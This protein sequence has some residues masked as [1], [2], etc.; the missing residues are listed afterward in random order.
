MSQLPVSPTRRA[1]FLDRDGTLN[2]EHD[3][4]RTPDDLVLLPGVAGALRSL[5]DAGFALVVVTNQSARARGLLHEE[6]LR[7]VHD[8]LKGLLQATGAPL[9][10]IYHCPHHPTEGAPPLR[11]ECL[12]RK[13]LPGLL[14]QAA[15]AHDIDLSASWLIGDD[16]RDIEAARRAGVRPL[17]VRTGKGEQ[18]AAAL[19]PAMVTA[20]LAAAAAR[21]LEDC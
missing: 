18:M 19:D 15:A 13:P 3:L 9:T 6:E 17:L 16:M 10:A 20:D 1:V 21:I 14:H 2:H 7:A 4:V 12:C 5:H 11:Q 8:H